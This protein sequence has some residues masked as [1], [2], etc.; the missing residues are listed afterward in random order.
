MFDFNRIEIRLVSNSEARQFMRQY[1]YTKSCPKST[2]ALG[3]YYN[4]QLCTMIVYG[5][6]SNYNLAKS[7]WEGGNERG[8]FRIIKTI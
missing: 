7:L 6:P 8:V 5:Q 1:H 2:Y 4:N 3:F